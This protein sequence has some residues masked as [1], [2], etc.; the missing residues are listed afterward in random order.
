MK[1]V[2]V[3]QQLVEALRL[4]LIGP[5]LARNLGTPDEVL[6]QWPSRWYLSGFLVPLD[7]PEEQRAEEGSDD[8]LDEMSEAGGADDATTPEPA[9]ARRAYMPSSIG[10]SVLVSASTRQLAVTVR[11]GDYKRMV[12]GQMPAAE[13]EEVPPSTKEATE[14]WQSATT[15]QRTAREEQIT[16]ALPDRTTLPVEQ[17]VPSSGGLRLALLVRPVQSDGTEGGL[18]QGTRSASVFLV[19]RRHP[20]SDE[21][22]D[23]AFA[24]Q[25]QLEIT[26]QEPLVPRPDLRSLQ[27]EDPDDRVADLQY[28]DVFEYAVGHNTAAEAVKCDGRC[29]VVRTCWIPEAEVERVA[30]AEIKGVELSMEGLANLAS[31]DDAQDEAGWVH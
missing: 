13:T 28:R 11:W 30:P 22:R 15:W 8:D 24:F 5:D 19:N 6:P 14:T 16:L 29:Q 26:S 1:S 21:T 9:A 23:E 17:E 7:A 25:A 31:A 4:D 3:R 20:G 27:S 2:E 18:P 12:S 10:L